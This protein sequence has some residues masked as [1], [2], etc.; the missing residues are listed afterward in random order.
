MT[1]DQ[2]TVNALIEAQRLT[3][4][5]EPTEE[6]S[7]FQRISIPLVRRIYPQLIANRITPVQPLLGP[8]GLVYYMRFRYSS[9]SGG[10][11][12]SIP[13]RKPYVA[14]KINWLQEGF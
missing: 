14:P 1:T 4:D 10:I 7:Q 8:T 13:M 11:D 2:A 9:N 5:S 12:R 3:M 6:I